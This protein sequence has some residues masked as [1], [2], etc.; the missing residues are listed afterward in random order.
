V[1]AARCSGETL[2][3]S[4]L[5]ELYEDI[6]RHLLRDALAAPLR[7]E[8]LRIGDLVRT[9]HPKCS[10]TYPVVTVAVCTRDRPTD[11]KRCLDSLALL[12]FPNLDLLVIDNA[13]GSDVTERLV[14]ESY[15]KVH[16]VH[17]PRPGLGWARNRAIFESRGEIVAFTDDDVSVDPGWVRALV[18]VFAEHDDVMA[19]TGLVVAY[20]LETE[21]QIFFERYGGFAR[22]FTRMWWR[23][24][25]SP[26]PRWIKLG[27]GQFGTG[28]NMA[29]RRSLFDEIG[30]FDPA[31]GA[32]TV[33]HGGE[34]LEMFFRV[35]KNGHT[36]VYEPNA[37]AR[38]RHRCKYGD[39]REQL[40]NHSTSL[41]SYLVRSAIDYPE[42]RSGL[43]LVGFYWLYGLL[44][45]R[46]L[47]SFFRSRGFPRDLAWAELNGGLHWFGR[48]KKAK[49]TVL[50]I[51]TNH[52]STGGSEVRSRKMTVTRSEAQE[53]VAVRTVDLACPV[54][55]LADVSMYSAV[56][57]FVFWK[58]YP[59]GSV[60]IA[61]DHQSVSATRLRDAIVDG[62]GSKL[63]EP[64]EESSRDLVGSL[65]DPGPQR[66]LSEGPVRSGTS[67]NRLPANVAVSVV[68][69]TRD[70]PDD[71]RECLRRL[72]TQDSPRQVEL[73]IVDN[74]PASG[75]TPPVIAEF[76]DVL[77]VSEPK[78]GLAYARNS[79]INACKGQ[80]IVTTDDDVR[81]PIDWLEKLVAPF[82]RSDVMI[83]TGNVLPL[84]QNTTAQRLFEVYGGLGKGFEGFEAHQAWFGSFRGQAVPIWKLGATANA[85]FR[86]AIFS[87]PRIGLLDETLGPGTPTGVGE[88]TY[89]FYKTLKAGYALVY[90][91]AAYVWH[92][93]REDLAGLRQQLYRYSKGHVAYHLTTLFRDHDFRALLNLCVHLPA[94]R[95]KQIIKT[96]RDRLLGR[97]NVYPLALVWLEIAGNLAGPWSLWRSWRR[98]RRDGRSHPYIPVSRRDQLA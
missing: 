45:R 22:G 20:E 57:I 13:P 66:P 7:S 67:D 49:R 54:P 3:K 93:H 44:I 56:R 18:A 80:I 2:K 77:L 37:V 97:K 70:R 34:D 83:V 39:L 86:P 65:A 14:C 28:A 6:V 43:A 42:E 21:A 16:Y 12:D 5:D 78:E 60:E 72:K 64:D 81:V 71:L 25:S 33:T 9:P 69:A 62:L 73:V 87:H 63:L 17:E 32:G 85:A 84:E 26:G 11:L 51:E 61:N 76:P 19:V 46:W 53:A 1:T 29:F 27:T 96:V 31:L 95:I 50:A 92:N 90:E 36:L 59:L 41:Y 15:P 91:P 74:N 75:L 55:G 88:D 47:G 4:I 82:V 35:L 23:L 89:L 58:N 68:V 94:W 38:H 24:N 98:V 79:G 30:C 48:Y 8:K 52:G 40:T 10:E